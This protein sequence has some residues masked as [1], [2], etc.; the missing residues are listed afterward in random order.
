[1]TRRAMLVADV[2]SPQCLLEIRYFPSKNCPVAAL[3]CHQENRDP[4]RSN[5]SRMSQAAHSPR[6]TRALS[7]NLAPSR[8][9]FFASSCPGS[10]VVILGLH[11]DRSR[12]EG[13]KLGVFRVNLVLLDQPSKHDRSVLMSGRS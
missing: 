1:M 12:E 9:H 10:F 6:M 11:R 3:A 4:S 5:P 8:T 13:A 2:Q 7:M